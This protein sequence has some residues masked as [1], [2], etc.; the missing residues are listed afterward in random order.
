MSEKEA[1]VY[2]LIRSRYMAHFMPHNE[3]NRTVVSS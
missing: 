3:Y 2:D 1:K